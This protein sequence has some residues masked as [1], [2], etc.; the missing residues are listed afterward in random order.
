VMSI[1][2]TRLIDYAKTWRGREATKTALLPYR[3]YIRSDSIPGGAVN[4]HPA[5]NAYAR[6]GR[7]GAG[8]GRSG[9]IVT[10]DLVPP[11]SP[12]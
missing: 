11:I 2:P 8:L 6:I 7:A 12:A 1:S 4:V 3:P 9:K 10:L 5:N